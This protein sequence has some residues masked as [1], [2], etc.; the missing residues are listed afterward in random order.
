MGRQGECITIIR[1]D[2]KRSVVPLAVWE[3]GLKLD[4]DWKREVRPILDTPPVKVVPVLIEKPIP[5]IVAEVPKEPVK[6]PKPEKAKK[7]N[8][9][10][11]K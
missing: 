4:P 6:K 1:N 5:V 11:G 9:K 2:G 8:G 7:K 10:K 3:N